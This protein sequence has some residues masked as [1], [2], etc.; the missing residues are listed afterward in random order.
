VRNGFC[1]FLLSR[2]PSLTPVVRAGFCA[3]QT[4]PR[5]SHPVSNGFC[6]VYHLRH[7]CRHTVTTEDR[8]L[9]T[10]TTQVFLLFIFFMPSALLGTFCIFFNFIILYLNLSLMIDLFI[11]LYIYCYVLGRPLVFLYYLLS[12]CFASQ[13]IIF[14]VSTPSVKLLF[15]SFN[16]ILCMPLGANLGK[17][18]PRNLA[19][20]CKQPLFVGFT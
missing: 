4:K 1:A 18:S 16:L 15:L 5:G 8:R 20:L 2:V 3:E 19:S 7:T 12:V 17:L 9:S 13:Y 6:V 10:A 14:G 11:Y